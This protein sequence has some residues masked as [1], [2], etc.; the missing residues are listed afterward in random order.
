M[1]DNFNVVKFSNFDMILNVQW[2]ITIGKHWKNYQT[3]EMGFKIKGGW[4]VVLRGMT[5]D[6][7]DIATLNKMENG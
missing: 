4:R 6:P 3:M 5:W 1:V 2:L 7:P